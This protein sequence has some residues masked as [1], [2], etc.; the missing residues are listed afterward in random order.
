MSTATQTNRSMRIYTPAGEDVLLLER[1]TGDEWVSHPF[2]Y[3]VDLLSENDSVSAD[4]LIRQPVHIEI[5]KVSGG[6]RI[7]HARVSEFVQRGR[8]HVFTLYGAT[9]RPWL[10]FLSLWHDCKI[11]QNMS[12]PDIVEKVFKDHSFTDYELKLYKTYAPREYCVQYRESCL[13]FV[14]RL[15]EDEGIFYYFEHTDQKHTLVLADTPGGISPCPDQSSAQIMPATHTRMGFDVIVDTNNYQQVSTGKVSLNDYNFETPSN[16][17]LVNAA[18]TKP[19]EIYDYPGKYADHGDGERYADLRLQEQEMPIKILRGGGTCRA[20]TAGYKF[21]L[22]NHYRKDF[23]INY[24]LTHV[25]L[26]METAAYT[27]GAREVTDDY[28]NEF[29]AIPSATPFRPP[30]VTP[31][32]VVHGI[33]TALVVGVSG[34]EIYPDKYGRVKVQFY[35]DRD[36]KKDENSSCWIRVSQE[37]AGKTWGSIHLPRIGQEVVVDFLEGDPDRPMITGRVYNAD[38]MPPYTLPANQTQSGIKTRS[39]K[40]GGTENFNEIRFEDKKDSEMVTVHAEKD[41]DTSVEHDET[42]TVGHDRTVTITNNETQTVD[43]GNETLTLNQGNQTLTLKMGNQTIELQMGNQTTKVDMG[44]IDTTA[45]Q[46]ITLTVGE[47]SIRIDPMSITLK[48]MTISIQGQ[49]EVSVQGVMVSVNA[50]AI[51]TLKGG[52][53]MIN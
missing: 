10:W 19:E 9:L 47:S 12:V 45:M 42:R 2:E 51:L 44:K 49:M 3:H 46:S 52:M 30:R 22:K 39:S 16:S 27:S 40:G 4:T 31:R 41:L 43:Q 33:Q 34:E 48:A 37:W 14:S 20:F 50:D 36:G 32:P 23:N 25:K 1:I 6:P 13:N 7:I 21:D 28:K 18:G 8:R 24:L 29:D 15:L 17:L 5:D 11:F 53:T 38:Q 35:W 26:S